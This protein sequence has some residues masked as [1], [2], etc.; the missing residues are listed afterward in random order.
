MIYDFKDDF[1]ITKHCGT[2]VSRSR[3]VKNFNPKFKYSQ[4]KVAE[5]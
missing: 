5:D 1:L 4:C 2:D 3:S